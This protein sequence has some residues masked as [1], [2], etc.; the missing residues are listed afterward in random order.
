MN[1]P[2]SITSSPA[3]PDIASED[4]SQPVPRLRKVPPVS[5]K[6]EKFAVV[7]S[8]FCVTSTIAESRSF[9]PSPDV[10]TV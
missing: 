4:W 5:V 1:A 10:V 9:V 7:V 6:S 2:S 3:K 8:P